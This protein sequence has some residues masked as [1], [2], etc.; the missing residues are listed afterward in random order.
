VVRETVVDGPDPLLGTKVAG[1]YTVMRRIAR[2]G[3]GVVYL[4]VQEGLGRAVALKIIR[5]EIANDPMMQKRFEREAKAASQLNH[6]CIVTVH[7]YGRTDEGQLYLAM[8]L[9]DGDPLRDVLKRKKKLSFAESVRIIECVCQG[10]ARAH[11]AGI[12]HRDLKPENVML[13]RSSSAPGAGGLSMTGTVAAKVL[14]FG[15]AK[16]H[17]PNAMEENLTRDGGFVG[18][19]GYTAPEQAEGAP[20]HPRQDLYALGV[21]WWEL[22]VGEHPFA[23]PTPM[24]VVAR[25]LNEEPPSLA[26]RIE[27]APDEAVTLINALMSRNPD[28]RPESVQEVL[29]A[30]GRWR[31]GVVAVVTPPPVVVAEPVVQSIVEPPKGSRTALFVAA[32]GIIAAAA[33]ALVVFVTSPDPPAVKEDAGVVIVE[34]VAP[35]PVTPKKNIVEIHIAAIPTFSA[36]QQLRSSIPPT[37]LLRYAPNETVLTVEE[38]PAGSLAETLQGLPLATEIPLVLEV[39]EL[40]PEKIVLSAVRPEFASAL[41]DAGVVEV[42]AGVD[43]KIPEGGLTP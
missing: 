38:L 26:G 43:D 13:P 23:A 12:V 32:G 30:I 10:L 31:S 1:R 37:T 22:L 35:T 39:N 25:Q 8:E 6:P 19:P 17:D 28:N 9:V 14:D 7:D 3:M 18:T 40:S 41:R 20:E 2:G 42:D 4:A 33:G 21:L 34:D 36:L 11:S 24:K 5:K 16:P 27:G 15:L 29:D